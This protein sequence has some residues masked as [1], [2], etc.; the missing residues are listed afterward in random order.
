[1]FPGL[2]LFSNFRLTLRGHSPPERV[3]YTPHYCITAK[4]CS[5]TMTSHFFIGIFLPGKQAMR[6]LW[7]SIQKY[8]IVTTCKAPVPFAIY[9]A[10]L[11]SHTHQ[12]ET[13][14]RTTHLSYA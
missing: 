3:E 1:M 2:R 5:L 8:G 14:A 9:L 11:I 4:W 12:G 7:S 10:Y 6:L 13:H